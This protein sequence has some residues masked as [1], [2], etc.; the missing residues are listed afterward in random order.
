M[1]YGFGSLIGFKLNPLTNLLPFIL[2]GIGIDDMFVIA[3]QL[4][5]LPA[6][7]GPNERIAQTMAHAGISITITSL[8]DILAFALGSTSSLPALSS[9]CVFAS[10]GIAADYLLQISF[11]A[12]WLALDVRREGKGRADCCFLMEPRAGLCGTTVGE[13]V[14]GICAFG[15]GGALDAIATPPEGRLRRR[16]ARHY[17]PLLQKPPF[18]ANPLPPYPPS[19][20]AP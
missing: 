14:S 18:K 8:T 5:K 10:V 16:I 20:L 17:V 9:F 6:S 2:I 3:S 13:P 1:S 7:L 15:A 19:P 12:A 11:F 4:D